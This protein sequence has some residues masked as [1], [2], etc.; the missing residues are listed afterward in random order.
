MS[1]YNTDDRIPYFYI[2]RHLPSG[3]M[4]AGCKYAKGANPENLLT[5]MGYLTSSK[6][7]LNLINTDGLDS[8]Q[9]LRIDTYCDGLHPKDYESLFLEINNCS[10][11]EY[12]L[13][14]HNNTIYTH[15]DENFKQIMINSYGVDSPMKSKELLQKAQSTNMKKYGVICTLQAEHVLDKIQI[16]Y[17]L[18]YDGKHP[19]LNS[20]VKQKHKNTCQSNYNVDSP[21]QSEEVKER[22]RKSCLE[23]LGVDNPMKSELVKEKS[24]ITCLERYGFETITEYMASIEYSCPHCNKVGKGNN[25]KRY[26]FDNCK[27]VTGESKFVQNKSL[28]VSCPI[29]GKV[30]NP[31]GILGLHLK[32]CK[33]KNNII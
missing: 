12:W 5:P 30:G 16:Q 23:S 21:M 20:F 8:F 14:S 18:K 10:E 32:H 28:D 11:S 26:H 2:I 9:I 1:I 4:Y 3:K 31:K 33:I 24:K 15:D 7:V 25:M 19:M 6:K 22:H 27:T 17:K 29:C 13:N